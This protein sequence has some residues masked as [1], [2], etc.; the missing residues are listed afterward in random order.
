MYL[1]FLRGCNQPV[2]APFFIIVTYSVLAVII[3]SICFLLLLT[4]CNFEVFWSFLNNY[5]KK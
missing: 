3:N 1:K 5:K 2:A 4:L